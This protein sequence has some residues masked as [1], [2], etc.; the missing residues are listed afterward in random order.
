MQPIPYPQTP[1]TARQWFRSNGISILQWARHF[2]FSR[3]TV[4]DLLRRSRKGDRG[5]SHVAAVALGLKPDPNR[6][7]E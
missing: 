4:F 7:P 1:E 3:H 2:G 6:V 5:M